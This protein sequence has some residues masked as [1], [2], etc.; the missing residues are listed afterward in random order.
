LRFEI[1]NIAPPWPIPFAGARS[2]QVAHRNSKQI[3]RK[4]VLS[5]PP[6]NLR[7]FGLIEPG[8]GLHGC[9][10]TRN[11]SLSSA[12]G[13]QSEPRGVPPHLADTLSAS[14]RP[15]LG[16]PGQS[17]RRTNNRTNTKRQKPRQSKACPAAPVA[18]RAALVLARAGPLGF[19]MR[20]EYHAAEAPEC[21][22][23]ASARPGFY[24]DTRIRRAYPARWMANNFRLR[25]EFRPR[26]NPSL[27]AGA[28]NKLLISLALAA[29]AD[30]GKGRG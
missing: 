5:K 23:G 26:K 29:L 18:L 25:A 3:L 11:T 8:F 28:S 10:I 7:F 12:S 15:F 20:V 1:P 9:K 6:Y 13:R 27:G 30:G 24:D 2:A 17:L 4:L 16:L 22:F 21:R 14:T 19:G